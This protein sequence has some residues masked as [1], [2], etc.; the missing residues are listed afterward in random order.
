MLI[1][2]VKYSDFDCVGGDFDPD[3]MVMVSQFNIMNGVVCGETFG[4]DDELAIRTCRA[5]RDI[6][7]QP[8]APLCEVG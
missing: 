4:F 1:T 2:S 8:N 5:I 7:G 6:Y 3:S